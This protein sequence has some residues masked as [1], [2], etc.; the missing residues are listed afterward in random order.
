MFS[1]IKWRFIVVYFLLVF[2]AMV[3]VGVFII[4]RLQSQ[5]IEN[6]TDTMEKHIETIIGTS[7]YIM[8]DDWVSVQDEIQ[9]TL[10][11]WRLDSTEI[12]YLIYNEF[13]L[14]KYLD[15]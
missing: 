4:S 3:I 10:N 7:S 9:E 5:Q 8:E 1:S 6:I 12:L 15:G 11:D 2:I 14:L 13:Y